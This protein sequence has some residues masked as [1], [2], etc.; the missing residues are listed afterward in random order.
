M[1][2]NYMKHLLFAMVEGLKAEPRVA[3]NVCWVCLT[4]A[5]LSLD[6][7]PIFFMNIS[8]YITYTHPA[9]LSQAFSSLV[10]AA[11]D[12]VERE[13]GVVETFSLS[14]CFEG[15]ILKLLETTNR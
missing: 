3:A 4:S 7:T 8:V 6:Y 2:E 12:N 11:Y 10:E 13:S 9:P 14:F 5:C 1:N 15:I